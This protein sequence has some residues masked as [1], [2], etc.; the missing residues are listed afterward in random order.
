LLLIVF[1]SF[2]EQYRMNAGIM[3]L[4]NTLIYGNRLRCGSS[5]VANAQL[6]I[7]DAVS[8]RGPVWLQQVLMDFIS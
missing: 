3:S 5:K 8:C 4:C 2:F 7:S 6:A 1:S